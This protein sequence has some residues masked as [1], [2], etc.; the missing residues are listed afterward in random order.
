MRRIFQHNLRHLTDMAG[1][2]VRCLTVL[3]EAQTM[4]GDRTLD[5]RDVFVRWVKEGRKYGLGW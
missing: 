1:Q 4:L 5:D 2:T 3:E